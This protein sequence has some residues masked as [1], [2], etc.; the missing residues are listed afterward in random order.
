M[1]QK[2]ESE[3][4]RPD[5]LE[6]QK[7]PR[8]AIWAVVAICILPFTLNLLGADFGTGAH[9]AEIEHLV[10][11]TRAQIIDHMHWDLA[12][13]FSHTI[14]EWTA[15]CTA[16]FTVIL[17]MAHFRIKSD[18]VTPLIGMTLFYAGCMDAFHTLAADRLIEA[19]AD[20]HD[21]IPFTWA[22]CRLFNPLIMVAG[23]SVIMIGRREKPFADLRSYSS[24]ALHSAL[25]LMRSYTFA[26]Q[27]NGCPRQRFRIHSSPGRTTSLRSLFLSPS[28]FLYF[29]ISI[30]NIRVS[31]PMLCLSA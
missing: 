15:F 5:Y 21:L 3:T 26:P 13:S 4:L 27:P 10:G 22:I 11:M 24:Q 16:I 12:G 1:N 23:M 8:Q 28:A 19:M 6:S 20:N 17:A 25:S 18:L 14:L 7:L 31:F 29:P 30:E 2:T 9:P